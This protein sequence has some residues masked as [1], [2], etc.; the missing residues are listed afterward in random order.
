MLIIF[1]KIG[2]GTLPG[3]DSIRALRPD[4]QVP[5][6]VLTFLSEVLPDFEGLFARNRA[7]SAEGKHQ[8]RYTDFAIIR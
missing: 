3:A 2:E 6:L 4:F 5:F 8:R 7:D 1:E